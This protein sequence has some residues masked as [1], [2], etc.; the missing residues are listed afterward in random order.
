MKRLTLV[1][2]LVLLPTQ[3]LAECAWIRW[4]TIGSAVNMVHAYTNLAECEGD[5]RASVEEVKA[6]AK[7]SGTFV[8]DLPGTGFFVKIGGEI[9][10]YGEKCWPDTV[11]PRGK[12]D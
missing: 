4:M 3:A 7:K 1:L 10:I 11:D 9:S 2:A 12:K 5:I 6:N 8:S